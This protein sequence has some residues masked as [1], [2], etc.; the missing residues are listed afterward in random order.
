ML[1]GHPAKGKSEIGIF[2]DR[3]VVAVGSSGD[4]TDVANPLR[5]PALNEFGELTTFDLKAPF[6]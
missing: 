2:S 1:Q 3:F 6:I 4:Q 5:L